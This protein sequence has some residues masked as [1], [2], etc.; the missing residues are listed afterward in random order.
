[1]ECIDN[2]GYKLSYRE[3]KVAKEA[4]KEYFAI[5]PSVEVIQLFF[6]LQCALDQCD[7]ELGYTD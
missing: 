6:N 7:T 1:M 4:L 2:L 5:N 3:M